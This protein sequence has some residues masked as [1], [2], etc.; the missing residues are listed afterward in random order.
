PEDAGPARV[1]LLVD[2]DDGV[3]VELDVGA[4]GTPALL[5]GPHHDGPHDLTFLHASAGQRVLDRAHDDVAQARVPPAR[6]TEHAD[7]EHLAGAR[8]V[9]HSTPRLLLD[10]RP[11][12]PS[13][14]PRALACSRA[15]LARSTTSPPRH[16]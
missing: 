4:V 3:V 7:A 11:S 6:P 8:V 16:R 13:L 2:Q 12:L 15:H 5:R 1:A 14:R 10:H 9:R